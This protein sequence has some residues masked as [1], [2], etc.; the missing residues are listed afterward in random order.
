MLAKLYGVVLFVGGAGYLVARLVS[1]IPRHGPKPT[2]TTV[3][4]DDPEWA[5]W[6]PPVKP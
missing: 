3:I 4:S 5:S 2:I 6:L 1:W